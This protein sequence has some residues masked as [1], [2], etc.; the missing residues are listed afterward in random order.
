MRY[1]SLHHHS[2]FS[3]V[4]G[5]ALPESH[6]RRA[7]E[8]GMSHI[9]LTEHGNIS[10][11]V[12]LEQASQ[13]QGGAKP[14]FGC[15]LYMAQRPKVARKNHLTVL[16]ENI[17]GYRNL[18]RLVS[19]GW[20]QFYYEPTVYEA[21]LWR[22][23]D[24]L[25]VLSGCTGS[26]LATS[27]VGGKNIPEERASYARGRGVARRYQR[28][29]GENYY[30]EVQAFPTLGK[31]VALN[32]AYALLGQELGIP[33][34]ATGDVHYTKPNENE[35]QQILHNVRAGNRQTLEDQARSWGYDVPLCP[36]V[37]DAEMI[38]R[39]VATGLPR[40]MAEAAVLNTELIAS[41]CALDLPKLDRVR[42]PLPHGFE[43]TQQVWERWL[44][45]G[46]KF[47]GIPGRANPGDY[48]RQLHKELSI[49]E[50]KDFIDY[51]LI[52]SDIVKF[53]K[54][55]GIPVGPGRGSAA[56]SL[57]CYL[58]RITEVDPLL[59]PTLLFERFIDITRADLPDIDLDFDD[60]RRS[61]IYDYA[62]AKYGA[63][64]VG[65]IGT[66]TKYKSK[67][68]LDDVG[69]VYR[70]PKF[71]IDVVKDLLLE[72]S[73]GDLRASATIEDTAKMFPQ[74]A[75]VFEEF[76]ELWKATELEGNYKGM[77]VHAAGLVIANGPLTDVCATY[78]RKVKD[79][80]RSV[81]SADK[82]DAEHLNILKIDVLG[83][84]TMGMIRL[85]LE[86]IG[87][88]LSW[89]YEIP[90]TDP[91][92][93]R[94]FKENDVVGI[95]Q[96]DGR[97]MRSVN[98]EIKPD[99]FM[100]VA[101]VTAL[102]RPGP[103]HNNATAE[104]V[105]AKHGRK[106]ARRLHPMLDAIC[107]A[108][109]YQIVYQEQILRIVREIGN[110]DW[111]AA[112]YIRKII[113]RKIGEQEFNRQ[114][115]RFW[116]G[117]QANGL[118]EETA[119]AIWGQCITAGSYAFNVAHSISYGMLAWWTMYLKRHHP[120]A[121]YVACLNKYHDKGKQH[122]LLRDALRHDIVILPPDPVASGIS[123]TAERSAIRCGFSQIPGL[124]GSKAAAILAYRDSHQLSGWA[125]LAAIKGFGAKTV[126]NVE[127]FCASE[128]PLEITKLDR[129]LA[130]VRQEIRT[131]QLRRIVPW[132]THTSLQ[133]PYQAVLTEDGSRP[134]D[135]QVVWIG[136]ISHRNLRELFEV[137][138]SRTGVPL[139][140]ATVKD[141]HLNEWVIMVGKDEGELVTI[142]I[143]RWKYPRFREAVWGI[144]LDHDVVVIRGVKKG[145]QSRRAIFVTDMWVLDP[146]P[147]P[148][149]EE[150]EM[151]V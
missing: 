123:F 113:S 41:R 52:V 81:I 77:G 24:G 43:N 13:K 126:A 86:M 83:L 76:P 140:P 88:P 3:Y 82:Y 131:G 138:F 39:L 26:L 137:N 84:S 30:L 74:A 11:H 10:S 47:R 129:T 144:R 146:D 16:A 80:V 63:Q 18:L 112:S 136:V 58:L 111:T 103:L 94:G 105:D 87:K 60:E 85:C 119:K 62:V 4:D 114:W 108:T 32:Q 5:F 96:Y 124:G 79:Q 49:I 115:E 132:P 35:M 125:D 57:V 71:K 8:L 89:L 139:D 95:F 150:E 2:T 37:N 133:I 141:P 92:V 29:L 70:I 40:K 46:W 1:V 22:Y 67:N 36:P 42:F 118:D 110:F 135:T 148:I 145:Y 97:A 33:L 134:P 107:G 102:A 91:E 50:E 116:E 68:S 61:E 28:A 25:V 93:I 99:N 73:S 53:A 117:A 48:V 104:Y 122:E 120:L 121:F 9:A 44:S 38:K 21:D 101:D 151:M 55:R 64:C 128:D 65:N 75:K 15:E 78:T 56:A 23:Q 31:V 7:N 51:F 20:D 66:F 27:I 69:R 98:A 54:D 17:D 142:T 127:A 149:D 106:A 6:V 14:I 109:H 130:A 147:A 45:D 59:Y 12:Q 143:D 72:R 90:L 34:V 19:K 100:E